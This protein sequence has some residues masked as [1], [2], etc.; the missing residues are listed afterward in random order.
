MDGCPS[1]ARPRAE[2]SRILFFS[3]IP[4]SLTCAQIL[5]YMWADVLKVPQYP[6]GC[7]MSEQVSSEVRGL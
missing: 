1:R 4:V 7:G 6:T 2:K 5:Y 3:I